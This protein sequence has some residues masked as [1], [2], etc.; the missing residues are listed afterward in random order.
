MKLTFFVN[1][2]S[3]SSAAVR[4]LHLAQGFPKNWD[5][6]FNYRFR[7]KWRSILAF[8]F[9]ILCQKPNLIYVIDTAYSGVLAAFLAKH[10]L[11]CRFILDTGDV[12]FELAQS[13]GTYSVFQLTLIK[14]VEKL[15]IQQSD[16][17]I[18][19]GSYHKELLEKQGI[20][21]VEFIPDGVPTSNVAILD[22]TK[23]KEDL[24]L[25]DGLTVGLI[26]TMSWSERHRMCY[27]WDII[28]ALAL[29]KEEPIMGLLVGDGNGRPIL[30]A[31]AKEL[32]ISDK[33]KFVGQ[34]PYTEISQYLAAM[35][36]CVST[37]SN[38]LVGMVR[39]TGKLPLYLAHGK[40]VIATDVGEAQKVLPG[41][42]CLLPYEGVRDNNHPI[43]LAQELKRLM[44]DPKSLEISDK[45]MQVAKDN[46]DYEMLAGK[47]EKILNELVSSTQ[48]RPT[49]G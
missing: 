29:L 16:C 32:G 14:W 34:V 22:H 18:V 39:T 3:K 23:I 46:F 26:G 2:S 44:S 36:A 8:L 11:R 15:A 24:G 5:V 17:I 38:D 1:G 33:V 27:G 45:A 43:R 47:L 28:E 12:A 37:Q 6:R 19:R 9:D 35:D 30:E 31:R 4:A 48:S 21:H 7:S 42:G 10:F 41:I 49:Q 20:G 40:Y 25:S 13:V